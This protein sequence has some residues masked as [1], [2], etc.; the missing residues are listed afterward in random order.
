MTCPVCKY[1]K[2]Q[3]YIIPDNVFLCSIHEE[4][5]EKSEERKDF[6]RD[7]TSLSSASTSRHSWNFYFEKWLR[8]RDT[9]TSKEK[10][11]FT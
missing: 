9:K 11:E 2:D 6:M 4:E 1:E 3:T 7:F 10:V 8:Q 5:W